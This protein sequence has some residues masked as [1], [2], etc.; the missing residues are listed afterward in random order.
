[1]TGPI[2]KVKGFV[3]HG[4]QIIMVKFAARLPQFGP[5]QDFFVHGLFIRMLAVVLFSCFGVVPGV[6]PGKHVVS[7][8]ILL[9]LQWVL[10]VSSG[11]MAEK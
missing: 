3:G 11:K 2:Q 6:V 7:F 9:N 5:L 1:M 10:S 8:I 4:R